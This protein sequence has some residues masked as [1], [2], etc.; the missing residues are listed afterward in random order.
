MVINWPNI[1]QYCF[2]NIGWTLERIL[3]LN[4]MPIFP[5]SPA[6]LG[7]NWHNIG[8]RMILVHQQYWTNYGQRIGPILDFNSSQ[9]CVP[10]YLWNYQY[11]TNAQP[12]ILPNIGILA[13]RSKLILQNYGANIQPILIKH[14][15]ARLGQAIS[16]KGNFI[17]AQE[18]VDIVLKFI[19]NIGPIYSQC[20]LANNEY[21][22]IIWTHNW[23]NIWSFIKIGS[24]NRTNVYPILFSINIIEWTM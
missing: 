1:A 6:I 9:Y 24:Q 22:L 4:K 21:T 19:S 11:R 18:W 12:M 17:S 23:T 7:Q 14:Y 5:Y 20:V 13:I 15:L 3:D 16:N 2:W 8:V 10:S